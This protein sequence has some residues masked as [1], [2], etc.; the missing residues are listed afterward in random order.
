MMPPGRAVPLAAR[1]TA[2]ERRCAHH[3]PRMRALP[4]ATGARGC[5]GVV[6]ARIAGAGA[7]GH[8]AAAGRRRRRAVPGAPA[9]VPPVVLPAQHPRA[10]RS[11][12]RS[13]TR[14]QGG[15][16]DYPAAPG[17]RDQDAPCPRSSGLPAAEP[18]PPAPRSI[19]VGRYPRS[20]AWPATALPGWM[21]SALAAQGG[22]RVE[23]PSSQ[24]VGSERAR[25][26]RSRCRARSEI[27]LGLQGLDVEVRPLG[28]PAGRWLHRPRR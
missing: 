7:D 3:P 1:A 5:P 22:K 26:A 13:R 20:P 25:R 11:R 15:V 12:S 10:S 8:F 27:R 4:H 28:P 24:A 14:G 18:G 19:P 6:R 9:A 2:G 17:Q 16:G 21:R 23:F